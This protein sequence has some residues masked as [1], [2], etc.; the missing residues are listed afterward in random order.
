M[1]Q[2]RAFFDR[3]LN[4]TTYAKIEQNSGLGPLFCIIASQGITYLSKTVAFF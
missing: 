4:D 1:Q 2:K 3:K